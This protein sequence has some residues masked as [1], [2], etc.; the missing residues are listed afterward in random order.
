MKKAFLGIG[1][2]FILFIAGLIVLITVDFNRLNKDPYYVQITADGEAEEHKAD[3]GE[4]FTTYWYELPTLNDKGEEK[5]LKFSAQKNLR[6][7]AYLQLY[8]KKGS[9]VTSYDE[10]QFNELPVKVQKQIK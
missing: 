4:I 3:N 7:D 10:V 5:I 9:E 2:L 6:Q 8:V 1:A